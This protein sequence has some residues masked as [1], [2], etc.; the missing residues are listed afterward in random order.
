[1]RVLLKPRQIAVDSQESQLQS[2]R[3]V[4]FPD[5][6]LEAIRFPIISQRKINSDLSICSQQTAAGYLPGTKFCNR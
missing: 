1:M 2:K 6:Q 4:C 3:L 5:F